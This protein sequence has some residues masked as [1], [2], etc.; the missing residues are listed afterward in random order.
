MSSVRAHG[1]EADLPP[2]F[3]ARIYRRIPAANERAFTVCQ[4]ATFALPAGTGDFGNSA[5]GTM[6]PD[7]VFVVLFEYGPE[8][9]GQRL[10]AAQGMPRR[11]AADQFLPTV[12]RRAMR[13]QSGT[14]WFFTESGRPFTLYSVLGSHARRAALVPKVNAL[15]AGI[16]I[17]PSS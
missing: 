7:D 10:F 5:V 8:S 4:F 12:L 1:V 16:R 14:Q 3:E 13:G 6:T 17:A 9:V 11:L 2:G 15:L